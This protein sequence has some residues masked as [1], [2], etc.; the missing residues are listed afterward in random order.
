MHVQLT[1][2][3][4]NGSEDNIMAGPLRAMQCPTGGFGQ[5][6]RAGGGRRGGGEGQ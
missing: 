6:E 2:K 1:L 5:E 4:K 3:K